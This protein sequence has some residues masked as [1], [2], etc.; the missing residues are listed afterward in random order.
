MRKP[1]G[2]TSHDLV[3][4]ARRVLGTRRIG[5]LGTLDPFAEGVLV[6][7]VGRATRLAGFAAGWP[8]T[9]QGVIRL[10]RVTSTDDSTGETLAESDAWRTLDEPR[11]RAALAG[12]RGGYD[13]RP[14]THSAV[15]VRGQRAYRRARRGEAVVLAPRPVEVRELDLTGFRPP[16]VAFRAVVG[17]GTYLR[18]LARD[19][20]EVLGCGAH[21]A[22]LVRTAVGPFG[23]EDAV[24]LEALGPGDLRDPAVLVVGRAT[25]LAGFAAGWPKTYQGVIRLG[26]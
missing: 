24:P 26:R 15:K 5:H 20:G 23:L 14:P 9:Y 11:V 4:R 18:S 7:V 12:F 13:Q 21:L 17:A 6:L 25:R 19:L 2:P 22:A 16:D 3:D 1:A 10:G 8:K